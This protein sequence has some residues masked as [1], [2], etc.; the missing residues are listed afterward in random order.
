MKIVKTKIA[1]DVLAILARATITGNVL[2]LPEQLDRETYL[3]VA[4]TLTAARGKWNAKAKGHVFPFDPREL[5]ADAVETG[6]VVDAKK[7]LQFFETPD[8][9]ARRMAELSW[10]AEGETALEPSAGMGRIVRQLLACNARV[11]AVEIDP[12]NCATLRQMF[13]GDCIVNAT[14]FEAWCDRGHEQFA[15]VVM[16]PP[17]ADNRDIGHIRAAWD[18][19]APGGRLVAIC[20]EG[21][22]FRQ[23]KAAVEFRRWLEEIEGVG[24]K[25]PAD[26]F[27]ESGTGVAVRLIVATAP[28]KKTAEPGRIQLLRNSNSAIKS[29]HGERNQSPP[30]AT[31]C[32]MSSTAPAETTV[33]NL[34]MNQITA[35]P[36]QPRKTFDPKELSELAASIRAD[37]LLQPVTVRQVGPDAYVIVAG[38]RRFRAHGINKAATIRAI[39]IETKNIA[40]VRIKQIIENDQRAD[41]SPLEQGRSYR[42]LMDATGWTPVE[43]G[44][45]IGKEAWRVTERTNLLKI[46]PEYQQLLA[47]GNL[48][49]SEATELARLGARG[50]AVLF[51]SI[52]TGACKTFNDL[53]AM[54]TA[55][56]NAEAQTSLLGAEAPAPSD[57]DRRVVNA[58]ESQVERIALML[59]TGIK[60]NDIVAV[61]KVNPHRS[62]HLADLFAV[63]QKD[64]RRIEV[65]LR[66]AAI[67]TEFLAAE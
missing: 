10:L 41:V 42:D 4:K 64:L 45:R 39:V 37:G 67:Q 1:A 14:S 27:R 16:N 25:L 53:R 18:Y 28:G 33:R 29:L 59:R 44:A 49:P 6:A 17:F 2:V 30:L 23:D 62:A 60:D 55:L 40:D 63:M 3:R 43:L 24:T 54:A 21:P 15:A 22:F 50:Q 32:P 8:H 19:V 34:P 35:D 20:S 57:D 51:K 7:T 9:L 52:K 13:G 31:D 47:S 5:M 11:E 56:V 36:D 58:F 12:T 61:R 38:E 46:L 48:K 65:A 26:T 66:E